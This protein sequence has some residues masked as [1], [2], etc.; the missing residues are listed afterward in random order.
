MYCM[1]CQVSGD[2]FCIMSEQITELL[3]IN[4]SIIPHSIANCNFHRKSSLG[5]LFGKLFIPWYPSTFLLRYSHIDVLGVRD[6]FVVSISYIHISFTI[7][8]PTLHVGLLHAIYHTFLFIVIRIRPTFITLCSVWVLISP[9]GQ[10]ESTSFIQHD[11]ISAQRQSDG[12]QHPWLK[13]IDS[14]RSSFSNVG[15]WLSL[16]M[17][18]ECWYVSH[19]SIQSEFILILIA[20]Y[21]TSAM[22]LCRIKLISLRSW[23]E[24]MSRYMH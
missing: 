12:I 19:A 5:K 4:Q 10:S 11:L 1:A 3:V 21:T 14:L 23:E 13:S 6:F 22:R 18:R 9:N 2:R 8:V 7:T 17:C 15:Q 16:D 20:K 24:A